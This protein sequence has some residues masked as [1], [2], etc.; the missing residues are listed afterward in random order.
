M[1]NLPTTE[2]LPGLVGVLYLRHY[3]ASTP[4][5]PLISFHYLLIA[6]LVLRLSKEPKKLRNCMSR[7]E[8]IL[9]RSIKLKS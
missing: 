2:P 8:L 1:L 9:R 7:L 3:M 5:L 6:K 4:S